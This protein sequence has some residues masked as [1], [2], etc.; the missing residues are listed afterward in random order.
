MVEKA[1]IQKVFLSMGYQREKKSNYAGNLSSSTDFVKRCR[2][3]RWGDDA[4]KSFAVLRNGRGLYH[5]QEANV[6]ETIKNLEAPA[7]F[8]DCKRGL[9]K[10]DPPEPKEK[11][12]SALPPGIYINGA[13][14][15]I[16]LIYDDEGNKEEYNLDPSG[17]RKSLD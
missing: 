16:L 10:Y 8:S 2:R 5:E 12:K 11:A 3:R 17:I 15:Q 6:T 14:P 4:Q 7:I 9:Q 1:G 13:N